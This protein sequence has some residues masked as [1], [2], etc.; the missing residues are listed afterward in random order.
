MHFEH[1]KY[2]SSVLE[3][4]SHGCFKNGVPVRSALPDT[5][6]VHAGLVL[7]KAGREEWG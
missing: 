6:A 5:A 3:N 2:T 1:T 4:A 7:G